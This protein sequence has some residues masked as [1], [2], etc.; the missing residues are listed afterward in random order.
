MPSILITSRIIGTVIK[1]PLDLLK[2]AGYKVLDNPFL[3]EW[4]LI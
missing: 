4:M 3:K 2:D 1:E